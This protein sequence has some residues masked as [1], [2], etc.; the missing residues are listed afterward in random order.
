[1]FSSSRSAGAFTALQTLRRDKNPSGAEE[2]WQAV[3][4]FLAG[5]R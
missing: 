5:L 3:E 4:Q 1:V 2:N